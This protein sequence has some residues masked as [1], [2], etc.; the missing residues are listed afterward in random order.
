MHTHIETKAG[1]SIDVFDDLFSLNTRDDTYC[2]M[3]S[4]S[5]KLGWGDGTTEET[6]KYQYIHSRYDPHELFQMQF[7]QEFSKT[8][9]FNLINGMKPTKIIVN[10]STPSDVNFTHAHP[11][12]KVVLYYAN[13]DWGHGWHGETHFYDEGLKNIEFSSPYTP[14]R[15][16]IFD[17]SI[18]HCIRPQ[19][20]IASNYRFTFAITYDY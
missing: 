2:R 20:Y 13:L 14:G 7:Y 11:E 12:Q 6:V 4:S 18:P 10:L 3:R 19:S 8:D 15:L 5:F 1:K 16:I 17:G 9:A